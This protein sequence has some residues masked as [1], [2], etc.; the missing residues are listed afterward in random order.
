MSL[1]LLL[2]PSGQLPVS[3]SDSGTG[4]ETWTIGQSPALDQGNASEGFAVA[5]TLTVTDTGEGD[6]NWQIDLSNDDS[7]AGTEAWAIAAVVPTQTDTGAGTEGTPGLLVELTVTD[8]GA[9]TDG[10]TSVDEDIEN[11][12]G[13]GSEGQSMV[14]YIT[15]SD[16]GQGLTLEWVLYRPQGTLLSAATS[17][18]GA[19]GSINAPNWDDPRDQDRL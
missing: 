14:V 17:G 8:T 16:T 18:L 2:H 3:E 7:G 1:L 9:G 12:D 13:T 10:H 6:E 11:D 5:A 19:E 15:E 4:T